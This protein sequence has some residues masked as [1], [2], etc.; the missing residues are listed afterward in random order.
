MV[1]NKMIVHRSS[2]IHEQSWDCGTVEPMETETQI[3]E[4]LETFRDTINLQGRKCT[5][6]DPTAKWEDTQTE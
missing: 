3:C 4:V 5:T 6:S 1:K 2:A